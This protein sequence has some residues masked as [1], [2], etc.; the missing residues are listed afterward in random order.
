MKT[1]LVPTD[2]SSIAANAVQ[3]AASLVRQKGGRLLLVHTVDFS[4]A[5][6]PEGV[7][8]IPFDAQLIED[9][10][11]ALQLM[12][13]NLRAEHGFAFEVETFCLYGPLIP[14]LNEQVKTQA[15]DLVVMGTHG[16]SNLLDKLMGTNA[17]SYIKEALCPVLVIPANVPFAPVRH[18]A[19]AS[20]FENEETVYLKQ[21]FQLASFLGSE[22]NIINIKSEKQLD[23]VSDNQV[24]K[25][26]HKH[27][28]NNKYTIAQ[29][30]NDDIIAGLK[31]FV[32]ENQME[33]LAV[34]IQDRDWL[35]E[36]FHHSITK[37]LALQAFV[38]LLAL[39]AAPYQFQN[40]RTTKKTA[41]VI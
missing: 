30:Q 7:P 34:S 22:V 9:A 26:I 32:R 33:V 1:I 14:L 24:L 3:Y 17:S 8:L 18:I 13:Q 31:G 16:E 27:F 10:E 40:Q 25:S 36:L 23:L 4:T 39:P 28:P 11:E 12:A 15:V 5:V 6:S 35:E 19:Y 2:F 29:F 21:L 20:D 38:P 41:P 37:K